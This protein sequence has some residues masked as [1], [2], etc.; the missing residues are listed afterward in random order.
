[1]TVAFLCPR[2][3]E[4]VLTSIPHSSA[5][6][7][8]VCRREWKPWWGIPS[9]FNSNSKLRWY[10]RIEIYVPFSNMTY[11]L[12]HRFL[13]CF[14]I[15]TS[16]FGIGIT[17]T[18]E[19]VLGAVVSLELPLSWQILFTKSS[20]FVKFISVHSRASSS[21]T[22]KPVYRHTS[23]IWGGEEYYVLTAFFLQ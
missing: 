22:R 2:I 15:G 14:K 7:A 9:R 23:M 5:L 1:M 21:P 12:L 11:W 6:V 10:E 17:R 3:S 19:F 16:C 20:F 13:S 8:K 4:S 18:D